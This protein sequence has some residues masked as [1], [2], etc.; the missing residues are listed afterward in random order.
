MFIFGTKPVLA[1]ALPLC[2]TMTACSDWDR[3]THPGMVDN[4]AS[5]TSQDLLVGA[6]FRI[7][8]HNSRALQA[9]TDMVNLLSHPKPRW[10]HDIWEENTACR[11]GK[12][13][14][15]EERRGKKLQ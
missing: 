4:K 5:S 2:A 8:V 12:M 7:R 1:A 14:N 3:I 9:H 10:I 15:L 11:G 6:C 13:R